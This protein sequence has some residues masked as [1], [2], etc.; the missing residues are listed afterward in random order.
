MDGAMASFFDSGAIVDLV[1]AIVAA[2]TAALVLFNRLTGRGPSPAALLVTALS[3][4][5]LLLALRAA[6][7]GQSWTAVS[8]PL[9][10]AFAAHLADL[11][12]RWPPSPRPLSSFTPRKEAPDV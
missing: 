11:R 3:G 10:G 1:L 9:L 8:L 6:L 12:M 2:E 7:T 5:F 4:V